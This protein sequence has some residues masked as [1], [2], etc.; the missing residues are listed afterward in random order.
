MK[1]LFCVQ[2]RYAQMFRFSFALQSSSTTFRPGDAFWTR[3]F[4]VPSRG[5]R[6]PAHAC[7]REVCGRASAANRAALMPRCSF[8]WLSHVKIKETTDFENGKGQKRA[9][10]D[11]GHTHIPSARRA[12]TALP[13]L[14]TS[15]GAQ[16]T[17][18]TP[19][20]G[21]PAPG[22]HRRT[23]PRP[24]RP[25]KPPQSPPPA[26][27]AE[28]TPGTGTRSHHPPHILFG[29]GNRPPSPAGHA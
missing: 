20:M 1:T 22:G 23:E 18:R 28:E 16:W 3:L 12:N 11:S 26:F 29:D 15:S 24:G 19:A 6:P 2:T 5:P 25:W 8:L 10:N 7:S 13:P 17:P 4:D 9:R 14:G 27:L 21:H